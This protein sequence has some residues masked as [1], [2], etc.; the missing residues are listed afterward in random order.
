M[1]TDEVKTVT[2]LR[3]L[4]IALPALRWSQR[5][6]GAF[7]LTSKQITPK[8]PFHFLRSAFPADKK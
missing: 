5:E 2:A 3:A 7:G 4:S 8:P 1:V 6:P